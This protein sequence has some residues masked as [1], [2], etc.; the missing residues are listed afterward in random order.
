MSKRLLASLAMLLGF[1]PSAAFACACGCGVFD[2]GTGTMM[3][4][5]TGGTAWL[6][7]D[8]LDQTHNWAETSSAPKASNDDKFM[9]SNFFRA[10]G[11]YMF[12]RDWG[13]MT[14]VPYV[15]RTFKTTADDGTTPTFHHSDFG[16]VHVEGVYTGIS[17]DMSTGL[18]F[19]LK[20][21]TGGYDHTG[22]DRD[23]ELGTGSTD[24]LLGGYQMIPLGKEN[25]F[26]GFAN[27]QWE[28]ALAIQNQYRPGDE[29]DAATGVYYN[30]WHVGT[31]KL[32]P[33]MQLIGSYRLHDAGLNADPTDSG[34]TRLLI[35]PGLEYDVNAVKLYGDVEFPVY[36]NVNGNQLVAP[37]LFKFVAGYSF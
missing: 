15:N 23:T 20:L 11:E 3:A 25:M 36:Q 13:V 21:P 19:G 7:Y 24:L 35:S 26:T 34:Y 16:D 18:T 22:F 28:H 2:V 4:T 5:D 6:E 27:G 8:F 12:S 29:F 37:V 14:M 17:E 30:D 32:A 31:G 33:L 1:A 9:Q 10:G